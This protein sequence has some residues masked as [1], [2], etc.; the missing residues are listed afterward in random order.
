MTGPDGSVGHA[1]IR[2]GDSVVMLA[3]ESPGGPNQSATTLGGT[4]AG[5]V[6]V[7][8]RPAARVGMVVAGRTVQVAANLDLRSDASGRIRIG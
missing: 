5:L 2:I 4:T 7:R 8:A 1:E 6:H 3:D